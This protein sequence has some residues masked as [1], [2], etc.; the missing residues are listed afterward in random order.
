[1]VFSDHQT[2]KGLVLQE[3]PSFQP[4][5]VSKLALASSCKRIEHPIGGCFGAYTEL[6]S[7]PSF[8]YGHDVVK[9]DLGGRFGAPTLLF[10]SPFFYYGHGVVKR[11]RENHYSPLC[12]P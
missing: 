5:D 2:Y 1:V 3:Y 10:P 12:L 7:N 6:F 11:P 8:Y 4:P 9:N